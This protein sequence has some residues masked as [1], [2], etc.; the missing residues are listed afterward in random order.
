MRPY[1]KDIINN[2]KKSETC[3]LGLTIAINFISSIDNNKEHVMHSKF[4]SIENKHNVYRRK[5]CIKKLCEL[6]REHAMTTTK[7]KKKII[8]KRAAGIIWKCENL[9]HLSWKNLKI[10]SWKLKNIVKL[11]IIV[12]V[13]RNIE[14]V[15]ITYLF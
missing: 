2:L 5:D 9:L 3:K 6:L 13:Q 10:N 14:V 12:I 7:F 15:H 1:L 4:R 11:E 8:K